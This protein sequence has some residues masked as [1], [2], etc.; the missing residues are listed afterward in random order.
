MRGIDQRMMIHID[1]GWWIVM[2][3]SP[4]KIRFGCIKAENE[5]IRDNIP[6]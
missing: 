3:E 5:I 2:H 6:P 1:A 4:C